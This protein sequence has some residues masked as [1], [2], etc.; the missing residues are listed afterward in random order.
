MT[1]ETLKS[2]FFWCMIINLAIYLVTALAAVGFRGFICRLQTRLLGISETT[3]LNAIYAYIA[4]FKLLI[5]VFNF[6]PWIALLVITS[7]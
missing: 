4:A 6:T 3:A 1:L 5:I 7:K 2:F